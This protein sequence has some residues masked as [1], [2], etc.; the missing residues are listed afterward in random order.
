MREIKFRA[1]D[2]RY[3]VMLPATK[4]NFKKKWLMHFDKK[5]NIKLFVDFKDAIL[6]QYTGLKDRNGKKIYEGDIVKSIYIIDI[7]C[8]DIAKSTYINHVIFD[9]EESRFKLKNRQDLLYDIAED[10]EVIGN[11]HKNPELLED[12]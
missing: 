5:T 7:I 12:N 3:C 2:K 1:W 8:E 11:I 9:F 4:I 10:L 6:M